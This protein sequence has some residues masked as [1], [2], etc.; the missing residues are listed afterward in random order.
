MV[1]VFSD[2]AT[3]AEMETSG[4]FQNVQR[5]CEFHQ[6]DQQR[7][8]VHHASIAERDVRGCTDLSRF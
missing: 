8:V 2:R 3:S 4:D 1:S 5:T 6:M 7:K